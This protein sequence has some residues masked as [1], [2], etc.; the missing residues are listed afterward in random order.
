MK[1]SFKMIFKRRMIYMVTL[2]VYVLVIFASYKFKLSYLPFI[3]IVT[4]IPF[5]SFSFLI[6]EILLYGILFLILFL[7]GGGSLKGFFMKQFDH[8]KIPLKKV[9]SCDFMHDKFIYDNDDLYEPHEND[10]DPR[11]RIKKRVK[12]YEPKYEDEL[13]DIKHREIKA[14]E[15]VLKQP[16]D[17]TKLGIVDNPDLTPV[18]AEAF[19]AVSQAQ[20][21]HRT[22]VRE[23]KIIT[24]EKKYYSQD[25]K[26]EYTQEELDLL[27]YSHPPF[28][29]DPSLPYSEEQQNIEYHKKNQPDYR[30]D[31]RYRHLRNNPKVS[32]LLD[33]DPDF[34]K[35][36][37][38]LMYCAC[39][40]ILYN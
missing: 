30:V 20:N 14:D 5:Y 40:D 29:Y 1:E 7:G 19:E 8:L 28:V 27:A 21:K 18:F 32:E 12:K 34:L 2:I 31:F 22:R 23:R 15:F 10:L 6:V 25:G 4:T 9:T 3:F 33:K 36:N 13:E 11:A 38:Q 26:H 35:K 16:F 24:P 37:P 17:K 39:I